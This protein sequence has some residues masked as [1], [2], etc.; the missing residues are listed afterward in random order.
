MQFLPVGRLCPLLHSRSVVT[1]FISFFFG[2]PVTLGFLLSFEVDTLQLPSV[3]T[4]V[5]APCTMLKKEVVIP[6]VPSLDPLPGNPASS[7]P[8]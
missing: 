4:P 7:H 1:L 6:P 3:L 8:F 2:R 5:A